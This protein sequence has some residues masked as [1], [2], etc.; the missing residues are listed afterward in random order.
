MI[1]KLARTP[2]IYLVGFMGSGKTTV[3]RLLAD[4]L[5]WS[6]VDLDAEIEAEQGLSIAE[7]FER[8]GEA[9]FRSLE[10]E[11]LRKRVRMAQTG[12]PMVIALGGGAF[13]QPVNIEL[14]EHNG[15]SVWLDCPLAEAWQ[16]VGSNSE[17]PLAKDHQQFAALYAAR[18]VCYARANFR[19]EAGGEDP[20]NVVEAVLA[21]PIF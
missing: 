2:A 18:C 21:L 20:E 4:R 11:A 19:V 9:H 3:G 14:I 10:T 12:R 1:V 17:R 8:S 16:R 13:A 15:V 6:F 5:G 7:I